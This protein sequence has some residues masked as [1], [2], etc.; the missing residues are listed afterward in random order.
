VEEIRNYSLRN[1]F[2][3]NTPLQGKIEWMLR[4]AASLCFIGHGAWGIIQK[5][6][7]IPFFDIFSI[8]EP[9]AFQLMPLIGSLDIIMGILILF[10]PLRITLLFRF[11]GR[12]G[13]RCCALL[14]AGVFGDFQKEPVT[15]PQL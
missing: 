8:S 3:K 11:F 14:Q 2:S 4:I 1:A 15:T 9:T 6:G 13:L 5:E 12:F 7:W 10:I